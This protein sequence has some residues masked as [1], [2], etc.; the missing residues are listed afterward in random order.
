MLSKYWRFVIDWSRNYFPSMHMWRE[1][2]MTIFKIFKCD[3]P[4][5]LKNA[6]SCLLLYVVQLAVGQT[7]LHWFA[8]HHRNIWTLPKCSDVVLPE[9]GSRKTRGWLAW[10]ALQHANN[11]FSAQR[12]SCWQRQVCCR[13]NQFLVLYWFVAQHVNNWFSIQQSSFWQRQELI[14]CTAN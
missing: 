4:K 5:V 6:H 2:C 8:V 1:N 7:P 3:F 11:W 13:L 14:C 9:P 12:I 10:F